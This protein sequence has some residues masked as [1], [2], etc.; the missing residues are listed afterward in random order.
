MRVWRF[1]LCYRYELGEMLGGVPHK[2]G[3]LQRM[4]MSNKSTN[5]NV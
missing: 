5:Q 4:G 1:I 3:N 2:V